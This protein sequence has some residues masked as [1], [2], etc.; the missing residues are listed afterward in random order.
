MTV[1]SD[2]YQ[3]PAFSLLC[4]I[5]PIYLN[6]LIPITKEDITAKSVSSVYSLHKSQYRSLNWMVIAQTETYDQTHQKWGLISGSPRLFSRMQSYQ[7]S[8]SHDII[9]T[10][11]CILIGYRCSFSGYMMHVSIFQRPEP[12]V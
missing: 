2:K 9:L 10:E 3:C 11:S 8:E 5:F 7:R 6:I 4:R 1:P 12:C